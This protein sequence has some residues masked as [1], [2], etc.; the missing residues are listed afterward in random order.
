MCVCVYRDLSIKMP[1]EASP[2]CT[3]S[4]GLKA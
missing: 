3:A 4:L 2:G 1:G